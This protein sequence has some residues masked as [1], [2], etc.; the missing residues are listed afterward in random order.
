MA[1][2]FVFIALCLCMPFPS[3]R[4]LNVKTLKILSGSFNFPNNMIQICHG[5]KTAF[6]M[7]EKQYQ[8]AMNVADLRSHGLA[9]NQGL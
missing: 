7:F 1:A 3:G 2:R 4:F 8:T 6:S 9:L 5:V